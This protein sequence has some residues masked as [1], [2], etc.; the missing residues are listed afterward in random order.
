MQNEQFRKY[1]P[2]IA[3][4]IG[5]VRFLSWALVGSVWFSNSKMLVCGAMWGIS[6]FQEKVN[7]C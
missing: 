3:A 6:K 5:P 7:S 1:D 4:K 2:V